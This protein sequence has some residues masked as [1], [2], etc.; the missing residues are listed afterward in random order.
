M[1]AKRYGGG[2]GEESG[3]DERRK[4]DR[5]IYRGARKEA[6]GSDQLEV[7]PRVESPASRSMKF[8]LSPRCTGSR[9]VALPLV[10]L[11]P[12]RGYPRV[13]GYARRCMYGVLLLLPFPVLIAPYPPPPRAEWGIRALI[14]ANYTGGSQFNF[15]RREHPPFHAAR[16]STYRLSIYFSQEGISGGD[17][18]CARSGIS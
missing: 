2:A 4:C 14:R 15:T 12:F 9:R 8:F 18:P 16:N 1:R 7:I 3:A 5:R 11:S 10:P 17:T 6:T 13:C